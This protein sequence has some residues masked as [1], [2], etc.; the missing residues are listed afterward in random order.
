V[1]ARLRAGL[2]AALRMLADSARH[3][4]GTWIY[5]FTRA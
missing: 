5:L 3:A 1:P 2:N 4:P